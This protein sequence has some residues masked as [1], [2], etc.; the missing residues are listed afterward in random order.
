MATWRNIFRFFSGGSNRNK[1]QQLTGPGSYGSEAATPVTVD[2]A[3]QLSSVWA[4]TRLIT[5]TISSLPINVYKK[6]DNGQRV[7][8][9]EHRLSM[10]LNGKVNRWQTRQEFFETLTYQFVLMGNSFAAVQ[11]NGRGELTAIVP[12]MTPQMQVELMKGGAISYQYVEDAGV[13][14]Y[15]EDSIWH[16]KLFGNGIVGLSPLAY[17]RNSIGVG[18]AAELAVTK[19]YKNGGKPSGLLMID[20]TLK[21]EQ[22]AKVKENFAD[23]AEGNEERLFVLE[24][25]MKYEQISLSPQDI[26]L[27]A[28]RRFQIEDIC[29][30]FGV[31][32]ILVN[33][34]HENTA[35]G[36]GIS[37]IIQGFYKFGLRP[38]LERYEASMK[39][40]LLRPEERD[41]MDIEF[42]FNALLRPDL[43]ER[44]K[45]AKEG[46]TGGVITPN[47]FRISEGWQPLPGGDRLYLQQQMT[48]VDQLER[49]DRSTNPAKPQR[50]VKND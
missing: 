18:Q 23:M 33:D 24:A 9:P 16:N 36:T 12:L 44:I 29:R 30:F 31:P 14:V 13:R 6:K 11:R 2:S 48:P 32:S 21:P 27:L 49:L 19:I 46:V 28:S 1:G 26:E 15:G 43:A 8:Y 42:D 38:Y 25:D 3:L 10:L 35:W 41:T 20:K 47:E 17:A 45:A 4:C 37:Q 22:R 40:H 34:N 39:A 5:E 50:E 7:L